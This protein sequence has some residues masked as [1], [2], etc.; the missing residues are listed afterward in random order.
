MM[1]KITYTFIFF[2]AFTLSITAQIKGKERI[3]AAKV[4]FI[5][6]QLDLTPKEAQ[7]FWPIYNLYQDKMNSFRFE[8]RQKIRQ[9]IGNLN[10]LDSLSESE[11]QQIVEKINDIKSQFY[12]TEK[13]FQQQ[14]KGVLSFKKI[15]K[16]EIAEKEF[17]RKLI[18]KLKH[19]R[20]E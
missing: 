1:K 6:E 13:E 9:Q 15:L 14:L 18:G 4:A 19:R 11:A 7:N 2:F 3:K 10:N 8:E 12:K 16:L 20:G 5:T 17:H